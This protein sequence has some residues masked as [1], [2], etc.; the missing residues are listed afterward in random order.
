MRIIRGL[1]LQLTVSAAF[2]AALLWRVDARRLGH[3]LASADWRWVVLAAPCFAASAFLHGLRWWLL[4]RRTGPVPL[5]GGVLILL[6]T[7]GIDLLLPLHAGFA[8][9]LQILRRRYGVD[10]AA[11]VG[12]LGAEGI[13]DAGAILLLALGAAPFVPF[14]REVLPATIGTLAVI[15]VPGTL[16]VVLTG[17]IAVSMMLLRLAPARLREPVRRSLG[18]FVRGFTAL[19]SPR[20]V[21]LVTLTT[22]ADWS[23]A[24]LG[25]AVVGRSFGLVVTPPTY[26]LVEISGNLSSIVPLTQGNVGPYELVVREAL[27]AFG[28][29]S[30]HAA[31]FAVGAH[32]VSIS[33]T[34]LVSVAAAATL[35]LDWRDLVHLAADQP[36]R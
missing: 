6:A 16:L 30:D 22:L 21:L 27:A 17:R 31:A 3:A 26:L 25:H 18:A 35:R 19:T 33:A 8:A 28:A 34:L 14:V 13:V 29:Q 11:V 4:V 10:R 5:R 24:A 7:T 20:A 12:S 32:A 9:L 36:A 15:V 2:L 1:G 23:I